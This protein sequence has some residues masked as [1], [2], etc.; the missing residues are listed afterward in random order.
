[1]ISGIRELIARTHAFFF[2]KRKEHEIE[3]ELETHVELFVEDNI[4]KGMSHEE[5]RRAAMVSLG[6][7]ESAK[8][9][10]RDARGLPFFET[11]LQDLRYGVRTLRR[12][13]ALAMFAIL[14]V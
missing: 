4:A 11:L 14:I 7:I 5:A 12:D 2:R 6:S 10:H 13:A 9:L 3:S 8:E 1:M